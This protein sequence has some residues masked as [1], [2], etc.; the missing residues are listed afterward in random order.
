MMTP[1]PRDH[2]GWYVG[3]NSMHSD[4]EVAA[5]QLRRI[6]RRTPNWGRGHLLLGYAE[7]ELAQSSAN[8]FRARATVRASAHALQRLGVEDAEVLYLA[9][10]LAMLEGRLADAT[11]ILQQAAEKT[12]LE[13]FRT[14]I[15]EDLTDTLQLLER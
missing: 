7:L 2:R 1:T 15:Q 8:A 12:S 14:Q 5:K 13:K 9:G 11:T 3:T 4:P 10:R 6:L